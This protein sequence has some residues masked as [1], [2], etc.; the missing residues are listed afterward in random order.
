MK[1]EVPYK[2]D[3]ILNLPLLGILSRFS[4]KKKAKLS[5]ML[6]T[7]CVRKGRLIGILIRDK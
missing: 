6:A 5:K 1:N 4:V 7:V 3:F 2:E